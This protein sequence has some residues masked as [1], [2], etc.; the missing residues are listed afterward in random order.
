VFS[1]PHARLGETAAATLY[2][3]PGEALC[4]GDVQAWLDGKL[5]RF[6]IPE[7]ILIVNEQLPRLASGKI[8]KRAS[9]E[10]LLGELNIGG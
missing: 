2:V 4:A 1:V 8:D 10:M 5:A 9:R 7:H 3:P 6:K